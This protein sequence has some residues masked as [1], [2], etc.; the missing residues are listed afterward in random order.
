MMNIFECET[1]SGRVFR[2]AIANKN[3]IK[4]FRKMLHENKSKSEYEQFI[5]VDD[6]LNGIFDIKQFELNCNALQ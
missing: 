3:Q 2:V 5:R 1:K 4:R 6:I